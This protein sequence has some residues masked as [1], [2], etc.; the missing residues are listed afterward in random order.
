MPSRNP[1]TFAQVVLRLITFHD[2]ESDDA[3]GAAG[4]RLTFVGDHTIL[5]D[6]IHGGRI[7][8]AAS[9]RTTGWLSSATNSRC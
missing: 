4:L 8:L 3:L 9:A 2:Q 7:T 6:T 5:L 1:A